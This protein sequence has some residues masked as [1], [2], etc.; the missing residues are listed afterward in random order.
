MRS[1]TSEGIEVTFDFI[2]KIFSFEVLRR[3]EIFFNFM[4]PTIEG[5]KE[6]LDRL[7]FIWRSESAIFLPAYRVFSSRL[8]CLFIGFQFANFCNFL[9]L[10]LEI[11]FRF[12]VLALPD[13]GLGKQN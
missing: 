3:L 13:R 12:E 7:N 11:T 5:C 4:N 10:R 6:T 2:C 1:G 8:K 9:A